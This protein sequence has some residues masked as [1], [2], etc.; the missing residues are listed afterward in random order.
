[1][2][3]D[4]FIKKFFHSRAVYY[5]EYPKRIGDRRLERIR[6]KAQYGAKNPFPWM[7]ETID[8]GKKKLL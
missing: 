8:L 1:M 3:I 2:S 7:S 4:F 6:L 5:R